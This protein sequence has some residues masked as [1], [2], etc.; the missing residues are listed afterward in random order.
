MECRA[1]K[2]LQHLTE[3]LEVDGQVARFHGLRAQQNVA[4]WILQP[5]SREGEA[6]RILTGVSNNK[7]WSMA[8]MTLKPHTQQLS[9]P[10]QTLMNLMETNATSKGEDSC[11][12]P[13][14]R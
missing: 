3:L 2:E 13:T 4:P 1:L 7:I 6:W 5:H 14:V 12:T 10:A 11:A 9:K 8:G